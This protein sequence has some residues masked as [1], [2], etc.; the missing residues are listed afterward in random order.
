MRV[1]IAL[2]SFGSNFVLCYWGETLCYQ[3]HI[4]QMSLLYVHYR[5]NLKIECGN[6]FF[7]GLMNNI[8]KL[9][10]YEIK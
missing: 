1:Y 4:E 6:S 9:L 7:N 5:W 10:G 2:L 8:L 3:L